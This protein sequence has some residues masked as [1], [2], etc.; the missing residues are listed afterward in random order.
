M[1]NDCRVIMS[2]NRVLCFTLLK[3]ISIF[4]VELN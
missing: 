1:M 3:F 4:M 2:N